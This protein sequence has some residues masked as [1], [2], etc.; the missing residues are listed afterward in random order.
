M[1]QPIDPQDIRVG[2][3]VRAEHLTTDKAL[4][5]RA[6]KVQEQYGRRRGPEMTTPSL[7]DAIAQAI[8]DSDEADCGNWPCPRYPE[9]DEFY[10]NADA[11][12]KVVADWLRSDEALYLVRG[13]ESIVEWLADALTKETP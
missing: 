7:R 3:L 9:G 5:A 13:D 4:E 2:D 8:H 12:L 10:A 1:K 6:I 11:A